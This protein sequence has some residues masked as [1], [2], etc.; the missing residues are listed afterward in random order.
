MKGRK[1]FALVDTQGNVLE[2]LV[3]PANTGERQGARELFK[4]A[5]EQTW[6][7][8]LEVVWADEGFAGADFEQ[9][10]PEQWGW[11][12]EIVSKLP[13][14]KG[15]VLLPRR[16]VVEQSFGCW[17][18]YRRLSRDYEQNPQCSRAT[19]QVATIHHSLRRLKPATT[20]EPD[21]RYRTL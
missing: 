2:V 12:L 5:K 17:G 13:G 4:K 9:E 21:F 1:R 19:L 7:D 20:D 11:R 8:T 14:Q 6:S 18:R 16:W 15:F 10:V 3:L